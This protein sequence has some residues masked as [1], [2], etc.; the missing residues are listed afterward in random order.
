ME[1]ERTWVENNSEHEFGACTQ[2]LTRTGEG[3]LAHVADARTMK[4]E[5]D[6][7]QHVDPHRLA[8]VAHLASN[9]NL[10]HQKRKLGVTRV[11]QKDA[12]MRD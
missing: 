5:T 4:P 7:L 9:S 1:R 6:L 11:A 10:S 2:T 12:S 3:R 8:T